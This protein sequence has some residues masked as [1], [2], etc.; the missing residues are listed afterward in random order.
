MTR[1]TRNLVLPALVMAAA[2]A[3]CD[4]SITDF[5]FNGGITGTVLDPSGSPVRG[6]TATNDLRVRIQGLDEAQPLDVRVTHDGTFTNTHLFPQVY[7]L[8]LEG[9]VSGGPTA[10]NPIQVDTRGRTTVQDLNVT[11]FLT[12]AKPAVSAPSGNS[13]QV[14]FGITPAD[15]RSVQT[16]ANRVVWA[17]TVLWPGPTTGNVAQRTHTITTNLPANSGTVTVSGLRPGERYCLRVGARAVGT[18][19]WSYSDQTCVQN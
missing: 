2:V 19:L 7:N 15:G 10:A 11:P 5:G 9:P 18:T 16:G 3:G 1:S 12:L 17:S 13:V 8:W 14:T 4:D 6:N